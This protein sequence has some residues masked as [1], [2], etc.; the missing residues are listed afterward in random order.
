MKSNI[1]AY[2]Y[3][4]ESDFLEN[5]VFVTFNNRFGG[6]YKNIST[7]S[8]WFSGENPLS[9]EIGQFYNE[10]KNSLCDDMKIYAD[11]SADFYKAVDDMRELVADDTVMSQ[12]QKNELLSLYDPN[13]RERLI[14]F[15]AEVLYYAMGQVPQ[16]INSKSVPVQNI[17]LGCKPH[18]PCKAFV[19]RKTEIETLHNLLSENNAV[20]VEGIGG[21]G[22]SELVKK[23]AYIYKND[24][25]NIISLK[26]NGS[27]KDLITDIEFAD[28]EKY[29]DE[30][31]NDKY[32]RHYS[33][34]KKLSDDTLV[35]IDNFD[36]TIEE[37]TLLEPFLQNNFKVLFTTRH[38]FSEY[39]TLAL[40]EMDTDTL[41]DLVNEFYAVSDTN[42]TVLTSIIKAVHYHTF[43]TE[44][45]ARLLKNGFIT[46]SDLLTSLEENNVNLDN[47]EKIQVKKDDKSIK[48]TY[49][50]HIRKL[51]ELLALTDKQQYI[52]KNICFVSP[53]GISAKK[54]ADWI[55]E[56][57]GNDI[58][59]LVE[60]GLIHTENGILSVHSIIKDVITEELKPSVKS[61]GTLIKNIKYEC[62][63]YGSDTAYYRNI[64]DFIGNMLSKI[65]D[66]DTDNYL[67]LAETAFCYAEKYNELTFMH[68]VINL[69]D[70]YIK[71]DLTEKTRDKAQFYMFKAAYCVKKYE[72]EFS[73]AVN[74][75][76]KAINIVEENYSEDLTAM[77]GILYS[78][79]GEYLLYEN[80]KTNIR[81]SIGNYNKAFRLMQQADI[82]HTYDGLALVKRICDVY[83]LSG[84]GQQ[85]LKQLEYLQTIFKPDTIPQNYEEYTN[86][87][88]R[89]GNTTLLEYADITKTIAV[90]K[91]SENM[92]Y[93]KELKEVQTIYNVVYDNNTEEMKELSA[94]LLEISKKL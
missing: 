63:H 52:L 30:H 43:L 56:K 73:S 12:G 36:A 21:I 81:I 79:M 7:V 89:N 75:T 5:Y 88:N 66:D 90:I 94:Q 3:E 74:F 92:N 60:L 25:T 87:C 2:N 10:N 55:E 40:D 42:K 67:D 11:N 1:K 31:R 22:K 18:N 77:L 13:N 26:Y 41:L 76:K 23:Y 9:K 17:I 69:L 39:P 8:R 32:R 50:K 64:I 65:F 37:E 68:K 38:K 91:A 93:N 78:N 85:A 28:D 20:F 82:L 54:F 34:L 51:F 14:K 44:L 6:I 80:P 15:T 4:N 61:C 33:F 71:N 48:T 84:L 72:N 62:L 24:Y 35:I 19:G 58:N 59:D 29:P 16:N 45:C 46:P 53:I 57:N 47:E 70:Y 27:L 49:T 86:L 83:V